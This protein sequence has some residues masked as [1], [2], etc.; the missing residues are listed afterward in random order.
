MYSVYRTY[1]AHRTHRAHRTYRTYR[2]DRM[3]DMPVMGSMTGNGNDG[4]YGSDGNYGTGGS[5][6]IAVYAGEVKAGFPSPAENCGEC[7]LDLNTYLIKH[8]SST[9]FLKVDGTSM[10]DDSFDEGDLIIVDKS[11]E[12][13]DG[14]TAVCLV[15]G[16]FTLKKVSICNGCITLVPANPKFRPIVITEENRFDIWGIVTYII[17]KVR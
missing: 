1:R 4:N 13:Y 14:C 16:E 2:M 6:N 8:P 15:D 10:V 3:N 5:D 11:I 7:R 12:P 17:K 9:F